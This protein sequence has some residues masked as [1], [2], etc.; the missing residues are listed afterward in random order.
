MGPRDQEARKM[1]ELQLLILSSLAV[2]V[3]PLSVHLGT[4]FSAVRGLADGMALAVVA[5]SCLGLVLPGVVAQQGPLAIFL[6]AGGYGMTMLLHRLELSAQ[7][8][9]GLLL[10]AVLVHVFIDGSILSLADERRPL[11]W[12][13]V[14]HRLPVGFAIAAAV[15][16]WRLPG[17]APWSIA[18]AI[19]L[20][21]VAGF[22]LG[23]VAV[24]LVHLHGSGF[25]GLEAVVAGILLHVVFIPR[26]PR[27]VESAA[28]Q[29]S[30]CQHGHHHDGHHHGAH[31]HR[32][33]AVGALLGAALVVAGSVE[34]S[35][36]IEWGAP[37]FLETFGHL[38]LESA[39]ALFL[40]YAVA[41]VLPF[42]LT[43]GRIKGLGRGNRLMQSLRGVAYGLPLPVCS[44]GV[45]PLYE[46]LVRRGAPPAAALAFFVATP[47]LG[48]DAMLLSVPLLGSGL[49][50]ARLIAAFLVAVLV[51]LAVRW[52][53][54]P[55]SSPNR[56]ATSQGTEASLGQRLREGLRFGFVEVFDHT[57]PWIVLGLMIASA[58]E[59]M[60][61]HD[62]LARVPSV[63]QVPLAGLI[64]VPMY[65]CASGATP[66]AA[67]AIHKGLSSGAALAFLIAGPAT[68]VTTFAVLARLHGRRM[69][70]RFGLAVTILA[71]LAGWTIDALAVPAIPL[72]DTR[73]APIS[74]GHWI[75]WLAVAG[76]AVLSIASL[77]RQGPRGVIRQ[78]IEPIHAH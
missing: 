77:L 22:V 73:V 35:E 34:A 78:I 58:T 62:A 47:E 66:V 74:D 29:E 76:L 50:T 8:L 14:A 72:L 52:K 16:S 33:P 26:Q 17:W 32:W 6:A 51:A 9:L 68:N 13:V 28:G 42:L 38:V 23:P 41:G 67:L 61:D 7:W 31:D 20:A 4:R 64:G 63:L 53:P 59:V 60:L 2:L 12:A 1:D 21:T 30:F 39:P 55:S 10:L 54:L 48:L 75:R 43:P 57:M 45:L 70:L 46:S 3:G 49:T 5:G 11:A 44:C 18:L 56:E 65:V 19:I 71:M 27:S 40:G 24:D 69:A 15:Q 37:L 36:N 25:E